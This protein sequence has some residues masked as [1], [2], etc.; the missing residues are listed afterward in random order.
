MR[1]GIMENE[2]DEIEKAMKHRDD[3]ALTIMK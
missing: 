1:S 2:N 3:I